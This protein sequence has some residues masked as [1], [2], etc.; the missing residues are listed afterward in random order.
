MRWTRPRPRETR[1][2]SWFALLPV[3]IDYDI[4]WLETVKVEQM[5]SSYDGV[6]K[7]QSFV[8]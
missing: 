4:R 3:Q 7:N 5:Y 6:W 1:I 2:K 8:D